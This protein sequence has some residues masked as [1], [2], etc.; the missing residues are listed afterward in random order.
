MV[1]TLVFAGVGAVLV[2]SEVVI[3]ELEF[4]AVGFLDH[5]IT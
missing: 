5:P 4:D 3:L 2:A 1:L